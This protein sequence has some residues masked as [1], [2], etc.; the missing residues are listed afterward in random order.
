M[1]A[2]TRA[3]GRLSVRALNGADAAALLD[4]IE[5][6]RDTLKRRFRW[7][8]SVI[9]PEQ[10]AEFVARVSAGEKAGRE[11][12]R[13][14]FLAKRGALIGVGALQ[15]LDENPGIGELQ[16]WVRDD[17]TG[18]GFARELGAAMVEEGFKRHGL[19]RL[20]LRLD[21]ANR[22]ARAVVKRLGFKYEGLL[23]REKKLNGRWI[24]QECWG[25]LKE[26]E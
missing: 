10:C 11:A 7:V 5:A 19:H 2:K 15:C 24:D 20:Y 17:K 14:A 4:A 3:K 9:S 1:T 25:R 6:S 26:D 8:A 16:L 13:G 12:V 21:P 18:K 23:R 22:P